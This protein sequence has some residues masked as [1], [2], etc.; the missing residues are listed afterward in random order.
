MSH[1]T[2]WHNRD[3]QLDATPA[4]LGDEALGE[5]GRW[6]ERVAVRDVAT[7]REIAYGEL[8]AA[9]VRTASGLRATGAGPRDVVALVAGN[10]PG[11]A[12][13]MHGALAAGLTLAPASPL[14]T[15]RELGAFLR[16]TG[17]RLVIADA[18]C[19]PRA[20]EA[21]RAAGIETV[22]ALEAL[23]T[24]EPLAAG[25]RDPRETALLMSSSGTTGLPKSAAHTHAGFVAMLRAF[26]AF[27]LTGLRSGDVMAGIV[28]FAH[29]FG[30]MMLNSTLRAGARIVTLPRFELEPFLAM[31]SEQRVT[32]VPAVPP[33]ARALALHPLVD[34]YDLSS[35]RLVIIGAAPCPV[36]VEEACAERLGC[37]VSQSFG[38][39]EL[40]PVALPSEPLRPGALGR[41]V[42]GME[43]V[44][45]D[46]DDGARLGP[47]ET[48][49]LWL[50]GP[51][52][53]DG[54]LGDPTATAATIDAQGW[55][56][57][58]DLAQFDDDGYL[59]VVDR[60]KELIKCRG[61]QVAPA[62]LEAELV[63][64][65]AV[66][67]AAVV[68]RPDE[69]AGELPVAYVALRA[70]A[71]PAEIA[72][73]LAERVAPYKRLADVIVVDEVPRNPTGKLLRR[74]LVERE[75]ERATACA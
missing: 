39:S 36:E 9:A 25:A 62:Q 40:G 17:A 69:E 41:L 28:P 31:I 54:Y 43:A 13:A 20:R 33:V 27:P 21:A 72:A 59:Y 2:I 3:L 63:Q 26:A 48:G 60:L 61:Y 44:V 37:V 15:A 75:R 30:S 29:I 64:H 18:P 65:P 68:P 49:E 52:L 45:V 4:L 73:W 47:G 67:D 42:P 22:L 19:F 24:G 50:R 38:M 74:V 51:Q 55:L 57:T 70:P 56:H 34:E 32:V 46:R 14:L 16:Q 8:A 12:V 10:G 1:S 35:L 5:A 6:A 71:A 58:G 66:A 23:P 53:M 11:F 7:G